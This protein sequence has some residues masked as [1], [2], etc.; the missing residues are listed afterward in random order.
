[1]SKLFQWLYNELVAGRSWFDW[2]FLLFGLTCQ[3]AAYIANP[4]T[5]IHLV[6]GI[7]GILS[8]YLCAQGKISMYAFGIVN[9]VTYALIAYDQRLY[10]EVAINA[11]YFS[12]QAYGI[13]NWARHYQQKDNEHE[14]HLISRELSPTAWYTIIVVTLVGSLLTGY[15]LSQYTNDS[16][17][18]FDAF[19][20]VPAFFAEILMV[21]GFAQHWYFWILIDIGCIWMWLRA[22][23]YSMAVLYAFWCLNCVYGL[24]HWRKKD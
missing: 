7:T 14:A 18:Y 2:L 23:N 9:I 1:M 24:W 12:C 10:G 4:G 19:T 11:F 3:T 15:F 13:Y 8:V 16:D 5:P 6:A 20:T 17:P 22:G 21:I